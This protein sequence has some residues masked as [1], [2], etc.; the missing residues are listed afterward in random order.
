V[1]EIG[2]YKKQTVAN[3]ELQ[4]CQVDYFC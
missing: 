3:V 1:F 2:M 4:Q